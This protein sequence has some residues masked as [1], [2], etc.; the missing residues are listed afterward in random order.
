MNDKKERVL[1][2]D[3]DVRLTKILNSILENEGYETDVAHT[4]TEAIKK[5]SLEIYDL[6]ILDIKLPDIEGTKLL[7]MLGK[8]PR[9]IKIILTGHPRLQNA[10]QALNY[11]ADAYLLKP[12][13]P[14]ELTKTIR[15]K[16]EEQKEN[17]VITEEDIAIFLKTRTERLLEEERSSINK[18]KSLIFLDSREPLQ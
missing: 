2:V 14:E 18:N 16:I 3:D 15:E 12:V 17:A 5:S 1:I 9:M 7:K 6:A 8:N 11:G 10:V 13:K 4:G